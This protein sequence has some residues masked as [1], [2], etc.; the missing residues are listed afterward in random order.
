ME[1]LKRGLKNKMKKRSN[2]IFLF[3]A[4]LFLA[5][6]SLTGVSSQPLNVT[7]Y[8]VSS[9]YNGV[10]ITTL[11]YTPYPANP[12][13][14]MNLWVEAS[15]GSS[16][17]YAKFVIAQ[18]FPF[19][20]DSNTSAYQV[21]TNM[22]SRDIVMYFKVRVSPNAVHGMNNLE[23]DVITNPD[24][25][26]YTTQNLGIY[27]MDA[28]TNFATVMQD[29]SGTSISLAVA[30]IGENTANSMIVTIP[31]Q[32]NFRVS[33]TNAQMVGNLNAGDYS[34]VN[35][36]V[37]PLMSGY[38]DQGAYEVQRD[39]N[40][41][42]EI[43][44]TDNIGVRRS[45]FENVTFNPVSSMNLTS[46]TASGSGNYATFRNGLRSSSSSGVNWLALIIAVVIIGLVFFVY[47]KSPEGFRRFFTGN[48]GKKSQKENSEIPDW[49]K[50]EKSRGVSN[51]K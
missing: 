7:N 17:N 30:N 45:V 43:D 1:E 39:N 42:V 41:T 26:A 36:N 37:I 47:K 27:V 16:V 13:E 18:N 46:L 49:I 15:L 8:S 28:Q 4:I 19:S 11:K 44:Y 6:S 3:A 40:L 10:Q 38:A 5:V 2:F 25:G 21:Y 12:G 29:E 32:K 14:Y 23:L 48:K 20:V 9:S 24:S 31:N 50:K 34:L 22:Q 51:G 33:G 35:F